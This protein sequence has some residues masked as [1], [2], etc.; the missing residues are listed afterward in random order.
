MC[1]PLLFILRI[2]LPLYYPYFATKYDICFLTRFQTPLTTESDEPS[3][4]SGT[5]FSSLETK[6][7]KPE[8]VPCELEMRSNMASSMLTSSS[9]SS[10]GYT[11]NEPSKPNTNSGEKRRR[12]QLPMRLKGLVDFDREIILLKRTKINQT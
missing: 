6:S 7:L 4:S 10:S 12:S 9:K 5:S 1:F 11:K 2:F 3:W 8:L